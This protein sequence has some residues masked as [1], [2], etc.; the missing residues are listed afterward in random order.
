M[1][2]LKNLKHWH[3]SVFTRKEI[4]KDAQF[5]GVKV[6]TKGPELA[7]IFFRQESADNSKTNL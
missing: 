5:L 6:N 7:E 3:Q 2:S 4:L 1:L